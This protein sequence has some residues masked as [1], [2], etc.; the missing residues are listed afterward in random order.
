MEIDEQSSRF[1]EDI[2]NTG[3]NLLEFMHNE[4]K[5]MEQ[6]QSRIKS[7]RTQ[8]S[9][10]LIPSKIFIAMPLMHWSR[11]MLDKTWGW[12]SLTTAADAY[13]SLLNQ[14]KAVQLFIEEMKGNLGQASN[15]HLLH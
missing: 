15:Y 1:L 3:Q 2:Q 8:L 10:L 7:A 9:S 12:S 6:F 13:A 14:L 5:S 4:I 11:N